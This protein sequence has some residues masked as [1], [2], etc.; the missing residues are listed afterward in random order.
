VLAVT[1]VCSDPDCWEEREV[2][3]AGLEELDEA[4]C[5]CGYGF[6]VVRVSA[7]LPV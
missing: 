5:G 7:A 3:V 1:L 4:A 6:I 2:F